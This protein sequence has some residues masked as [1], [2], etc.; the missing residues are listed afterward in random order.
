MISLIIDFIIVLYTM[1]IIFSIVVISL[2][3]SFCFNFCSWSVLY[4]IYVL[5]VSSGFY[6]LPYNV[7]WETLG[8]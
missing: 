5:G 6:G 1:G 3:C 7:K 8:A 2:V 4:Y